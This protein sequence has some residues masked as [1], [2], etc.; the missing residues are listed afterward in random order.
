MLL[1]I[2]IPIILK[3]KIEKKKVNKGYNNNAIDAEQQ[4]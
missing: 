3:D 2:D 1:T 4:T